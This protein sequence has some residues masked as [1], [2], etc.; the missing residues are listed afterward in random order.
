MRFSEMDSLTANQLDFV[1]RERRSQVVRLVIAFMGTMLISF[2]F[3]YAPLFRHSEVYAP[4]LTILMIAMLCIYTV[5][6]KQMG[7][8]LIMST[9]YQNMLLL[10]AV[11]QGASFTL[12]VRRDGTI[13]YAND[14]FSKVFSGF[15]YAR[16][17]ALEGVFERAGVPATDRERIMAS[18]RSATSDHIIF[19]VQVKHDYKKEYI[20]T[21][22]PLVRPS[23]FSVIRGREY[24]GQRS[25]AQLLPDILRS[26]SVD[27]LDQML[28]NTPVGHYTTDLYGRFEYVTPALEQMLDYDPGSVVTNRLSLYHL[29]FSLGSQTVTE[30]YTLADYAGEA[31]LIQ[32]SGA[33]VTLLL[34]QHIVRDGNGKIIGATGTVLPAV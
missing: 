23:G 18:I 11:N 28:S 30:E 31:T 6:Q 21:V 1:P 12:F 3:A 25:G 26:T 9:E 16:S 17:Q 32:R 2:I 4:L 10:E 8:D 19:P 22:D 5:Y 27:K 13:I 20:L 24:H 29:I 14:G 15:D 7:L 33:R 34:D